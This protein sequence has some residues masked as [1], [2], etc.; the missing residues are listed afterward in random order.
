MTRSCR[1]FCLMLSVLIAAPLA[2]QEGPVT[3]E[4][5]FSNHG[6]RSMGLGGAFAALA[7]D[8]TAAFA[9]PAGLVQLLEPEVSFEARSWSYDTPFVAGG[10]VSGLPTGIGVDTASGLRYGVSSN[11]LTG[12]SYL[13]FV[14]PGQKWSIAAYRH[15]WANFA[16]V[17][18]VDSLFGVVDGELER[19]EDILATTDFQVINNGLAGA[20]ELTESLSLGFGVV[21]FQA[22][23]DSV[24]EEFASE[25]EG[26]FEPSPLRPELLD[27]TYLR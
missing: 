25:D 14:Y 17:R 19:S 15:Q 26:F 21:Y 16:L 27:T 8:A 12:I 18:Q 13:S 9:N 23:M 3:F 11:D 4:F 6:A 5:S 24:S 2:A 7:D 1:D 22:E 10:R 20:Y